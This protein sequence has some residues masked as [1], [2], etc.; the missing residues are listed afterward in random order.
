MPHGLQLLF[1]IALFGGKGHSLVFYK[2]GDE[3]FNLLS[4]L[5]KKR[6]FDSFFVLDENFLLYK[7]R[8]LRLLELMRKAQ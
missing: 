7:E 3:L 8:S 4:Q 5:E 6:G 1:N 2:T